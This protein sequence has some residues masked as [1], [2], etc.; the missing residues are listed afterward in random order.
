MLGVL[1]V[2]ALMNW[3]GRGAGAVALAAALLPPK[4][5]LIKDWPVTSDCDDLTFLAAAVTFLAVSLCDCEASAQER[6]RKE[7]ESA[8]ARGRARERE[9]KRT[10]HTTSGCAVDHPT[11]YMQHVAVPSTRP[12][13][14]PPT[15][16][17][18]RWSSNTQFASPHGDA[19]PHTKHIRTF[20]TKQIHTT[21]NTPHHMYTIDMNT[22]TL[23]FAAALTPSYVVCVHVW[24][25]SSPHP[26]RPPTHIRLNVSHIHSV[27]SGAQTACSLERGVIGEGCWNS[28]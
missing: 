21:H 5:D 3:V 9:R 11:A 7:R 24:F 26:P 17:V 15:R 16:G 22:N 1:A 20:S 19:R 8:R 6:H 28:G 23:S 18:G 12:G 4:K 13:D 27:R 2:A 14:C 25:S 10:T